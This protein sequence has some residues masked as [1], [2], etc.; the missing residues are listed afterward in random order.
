MIS[1]NCLYI[2]SDYIEAANI[3]E[4]YHKTDRSSWKK[5]KLLSSILFYQD[6]T[7]T[8]MMFIDENYFIW[9]INHFYAYKIRY[10]K[11]WELK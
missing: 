10:P 2:G 1:N 8:N 5:Y 9:N 11:K 6:D 3:F 7:E 4:N